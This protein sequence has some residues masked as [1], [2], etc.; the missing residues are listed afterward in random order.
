M[1]EVDT[2]A[3]EPK[4][5][6]QLDSVKYL[7]VIWYD[8]VYCECLCHVCGANAWLIRDPKGRPTGRWFNGMRGYLTP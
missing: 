7:T 8:G 2:I 5:F 1:N 4:E 6:Q 3:V